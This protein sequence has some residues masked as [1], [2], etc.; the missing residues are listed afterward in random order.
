[1]RNATENRLANRCFRRNKIPKAGMFRHWRSATQL[2]Q[3]TTILERFVG[4]VQRCLREEAIDGSGA[5]FSAMIVCPDP[6]GWASTAPRGD[7]SSEQLEYFRINDR[8]Q[9]FRVRPEYDALRAPL[10]NTITFVYELKIESGNPVAVIHSLY[11]G[12]DIGELRGDVSARENIVFFDW[13]HP[14]A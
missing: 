2:F 8:A 6:V 5:T 1:M 14:G 13:D 4:E 12:K 9:G 7:F 11:P 10:T 3:D